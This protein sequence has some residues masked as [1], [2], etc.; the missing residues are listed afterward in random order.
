MYLNTPIRK[1]EPDVLNERNTV[2]FMVD[3]ILKK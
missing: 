3:A 2:T 1:I